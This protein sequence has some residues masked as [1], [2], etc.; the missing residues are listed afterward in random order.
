MWFLQ[1][2]E[3]GLAWPQDNKIQLDSIV[4]SAAI[5]VDGLLYFGSK[6]WYLYAIAYCYP[7]F[8]CPS[9][10]NSMTTAPQVCP[11]GTYSPVAYS[12]F[13]IQSCLGCPAGYYAQKTQTGPSPALQVPTQ[14]LVPPM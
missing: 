10:S 7:G 5:G 14:V 13:N 4:G 2:I 6:D 11:S 1:D 12:A 9:S 8:Y 3:S